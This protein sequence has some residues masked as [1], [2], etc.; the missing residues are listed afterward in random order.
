MEMVKILLENGARVNTPGHENTTAL[1][2][3]VLEGNTEMVK[4]LLKYGADKNA[5]NIYGETPM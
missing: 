4:L 3:A 5:R 2:Q 1:H